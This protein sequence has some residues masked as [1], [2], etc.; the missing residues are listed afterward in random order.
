LD[1]ALLAP[2]CGW[3][4]ALK[5]ERHCRAGVQKRPKEGA[6]N[7]AGTPFAPGDLSLPSVARAPIEAQRAV[8]AAGSF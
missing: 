4:P 1:V 2:T 8:E 6:S 7:P 3:L 5:I